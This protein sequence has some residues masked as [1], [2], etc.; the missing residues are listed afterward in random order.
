M[1]AFNAA[2]FQ[3]LCWEGN[4]R[5]LFA[6]FHALSTL[7]QQFQVPREGLLGFVQFLSSSSTGPLPVSASSSSSNLP[8]SN[9]PSSNLSS[10]N[11]SSSNLPST[12]P[13]LACSS[14]SLRSSSVAS[15]VDFAQSVAHV[16]E[17]FL[18]MK[19]SMTI[20]EVQSVLHVASHISV[21]DADAAKECLLIRTDLDGLSRFA[22]FRPETGSV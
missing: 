20:D 4:N 2:T 11:L 3:R 19:A 21:M 8:S 9:L 13:P 10:S 14:R 1:A 12:Y 16:V 6:F 17:T 22:I 15:P 5:A 18:G 7:Q